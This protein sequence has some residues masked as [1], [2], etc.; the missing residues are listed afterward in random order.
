VQARGRTTILRIN[1]RNT[2]E[3]LDYAYRFAKHY[4]APSDSDE[5]HIPLIEPQGAGRHGPKPYLKQL[6]SFDDEVRYLSHTLKRLNENGMPW[7]DMCVTYHSRW[8]GEGLQTAFEQAGIP[9]QWLASSQDKKSFRPGHDSV[10]LMTMHSSKGLEFPLVAI[11]GLG[12][13]P[14]DSHDLAPEAKLLYVAMTRSTDKL[15]L[16]C[17]QQSDFV[18]L[19]S[20]NQ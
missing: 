20:E 7:M 2:D 10:K 1:Y 17:H 12:Y 14:H 6:A 16:T 5:D 13:M 3:I 4:L 9:T 11:A 8:M 19:L 18:R 15:L